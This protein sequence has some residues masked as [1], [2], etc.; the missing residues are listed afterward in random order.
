M[1]VEALLAYQL[2]SSLLTTTHGEELISIGM[3][4][5]CL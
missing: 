3:S 1:L 2:T 4:M 5:Q